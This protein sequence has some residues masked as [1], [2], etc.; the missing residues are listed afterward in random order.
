VTLR[1]RLTLIYGTLFLLLAAALLLV[2]YVIARRAVEARFRVII[3]KV[4]PD[5]VAGAPGPGG[6]ARGLFIDQVERQRDAILSQLLQGAVLTVLALGLVAVVVGY[7]V[8]GRTLRPLQTVTATARRLSEST[9]HERIGLTGPRDEIKELADTFDGMLDRLHRAFDSQRRFI[10]NASHEL[11][12]PLAIN[13]TVVEVAMAKPQTP[14]ETKALGRKLLDT[15]ARHERLIEGLLLLARSEREVSARSPVDLAALSEDTIDHQC[16]EA[17]GAAG[18]TI[19]KALSPSRTAGDVLLLERCVANLVENAIKY[20]VRDG[21]VW[22]LTGETDG[23]AYLRVENTGPPVSPA[24][25]G[26]IFEPFRRLRADRLASAGGAGLGL[27]IVRAVVRA[28]GGA[29]DAAPRPAGGLAIT[30]QLPRSGAPNAAIQ[31]S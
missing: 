17:G 18:V 14:P 4:S 2:T 26:I 28:H 12:T 3:N 16:G 31:P 13:R 8:A 29:I 10:A 22:V 25:T 23:W 1:A 27:S 9:L 6:Q 11:R 7:L 19:T 20:N 15:T 5:G 24:E 30:V 21:N